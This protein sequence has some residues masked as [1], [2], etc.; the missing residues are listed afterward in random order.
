MEPFDQT[1]GAGV[2][3]GGSDTGYAEEFHQVFPKVGLE[4]ASSV[5]SEGGWNAKSR[6]PTQQ[7][8]LDDS[9]RGG[10]GERNDFWPTGEAIHAG[11]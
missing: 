4:L 3:G 9:L 6:Y 7:E 8:C 5:R 11:E 10:V 2:V 1:V